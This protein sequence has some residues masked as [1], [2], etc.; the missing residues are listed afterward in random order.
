MKKLREWLSVQL[1][2]NP[3]RIVLLAILLFNILFIILAAFIIGSWRLSGT[4]EMDAFTAA[5]ST[6]MLL[7]DPGS[8]ESV[9]GEIG[10]SGVAISVVCLVVVLVGMVTFTGAVIGYVTNYI[11]SFI[12]NANEGTHL[13]QISD[14]FVILNWNSRASEI[15]NDLLYDR[16]KRR[17]VVLADSGKDEIS[18][19]I[20]ERLADTIKKENDKLYEECRNLGLIRGFFKYN[21]EKLRNR[22]DVII[23]EGDVFSSKQLHDISLEKAR[24]VVI[25]SAESGA[26]SDNGEGNDI[27]EHGRGNVQ[28][29]KTLMQVS[30]ITASDYSSDDQKIIVE[31]DDDWTW[32]LVTKIIDYKQKAGKCNIISIRV[33]RVLGCLLSQFSLMP[34]L[35][36][37]FRELFSNKGATF[38]VEEIG[39][40]GQAD[41]NVAGDPQK[42]AVSRRKFEEDK[43]YVTEYLNSHANA[44]PLAS[45]N[46]SGKDY[47]YYSAEDENDIHKS[48][49]VRDGGRSV[50]L[51]RDYKIGKKNVIILGHNDKSR[52]I[53]EG[54]KAFMGEWEREDSELLRI[55][56]IDDKASLERL[57]FYQDYPFVAKYVA[58]DIYDKELISTAIDEFMRINKE[59][60]SILILSDDSVPKDRIDSCA[61]AN[62]VYVQDI[63]NHR[64]KADPDFDEEYIDIIVEIA[65][66]KHYDIV[67]S[68]SVN[69]IVISNRYISKMITQ[70]G[71]KEAIYDFYHDILTY[72]SYDK[73]R[74][75][76]PDRIRERNGISLNEAGTFT[77]ENAEISGDDGNAGS[78]AGTSF[79]SKEIYAKKVGDFFDEVPAEMTEGDFVR[80]VWKASIDDSIPQNEQHPTVVIGYVKHGGIVKLF[81]SDRDT[82]I[83]SLEKNDKIIVFT[84][85]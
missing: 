66:P 60:I 77:E 38:Y 72:D 1:A 34:E 59:D 8:V 83:L 25:L 53:M 82:T 75:E 21:R 76:E 61:L 85:H 69:N 80:A 18:K 14:H 51:T 29:V 26:S 71:Q 67:S 36:I 12:E 17:V 39:R 49:T 63:I 6:I 33:N 45:M 2:K 70:I 79:D 3:G 22:M 81:G 55:V 64:M 19:E 27:D 74:A 52:D 47:F 50:N 58:A 9:A 44:L 54:F 7:L 37:A 42:E 46:V 40:K 24:S 35:N 48:C 30:D 32:E 73:N 11:S 13:L 57:G 20:E 16:K 10:T 68:Y 62:L 78:V 56:V 41:L 84:N 23:R 31:I 43:K 15:V 65:D 5:Y 28:T 4:E